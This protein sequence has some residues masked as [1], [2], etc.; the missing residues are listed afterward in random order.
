MNE[1]VLSLLPIAVRRKVRAIEAAVGGEIDFRPPRDGDPAHLVNTDFPVLDCW[2][3]PDRMNVSL[4]WPSALPLSPHRIAHEI[5][6]AH[7]KL[8]DGVWWLSTVAERDETVL[9]ISNDIEHLYVVP[10]EMERFPEARTF[11]ERTYSPMVAELVELPSFV[12][13]RSRD[14]M[15]RAALRHWVFASLVLP[16]NSLL[17]PLEKLLKHYGRYATAQLLVQ[18]IR[19]ASSEVDVARLLLHALEQ[20]VV[21]PVMLAYRLRAGEAPET[22]VQPLGAGAR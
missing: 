14:A 12:P 15:W 10:K 8:V 16:G 20:P 21:E 11:W 7:R 22:L 3:Q 13:Q 17:A 19:A 18:D 1:D 6:H 9:S 4:V 5:E 2:P